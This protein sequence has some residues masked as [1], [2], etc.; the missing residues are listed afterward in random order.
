VQLQHPIYETAALEWLQL[1]ERLRP[2]DA[3]QLKYRSYELRTDC[4]QEPEFARTSSYAGPTAAPG[5]LSE[6]PDW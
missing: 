3:A 1:N 2:L 6:T 4:A 5:R